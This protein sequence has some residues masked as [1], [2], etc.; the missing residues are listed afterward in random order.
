MLRYFPFI[1]WINCIE[2]LLIVQPFVSN[3]SKG[4]RGAKICNSRTLC[5]HLAI[6]SLWQESEW[7]CICV[8]GVSILPPLTIFYWI[9]E[10]SDSVVFFAFHFCAST[11]L[12][13]S[14]AKDSGYPTSITVT[15]ATPLADT[16]R[17]ISYGG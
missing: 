10:L 8:L 11:F 12:C 16:V 13:Q 2:F 7:S 6:D 15:S 17:Y 1:R 3:I 5:L 14:N 4:I 9:L